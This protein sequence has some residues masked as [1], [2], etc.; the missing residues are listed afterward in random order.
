MRRFEAVTGMESLGL[1]DGTMAIS[2]TFVRA[3]GH[4]TIGNNISSLG[5]FLTSD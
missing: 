5:G 3:G 1:R 4:F 2:D